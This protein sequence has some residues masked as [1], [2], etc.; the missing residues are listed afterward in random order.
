MTKKDCVFV[1]GAGGFIGTAI[2]EKISGAVPLVG[3]DSFVRDVHPAGV[4][5]FRSASY[6]ALFAG[7][8][9]DSKLLAAIFQ[10]WNPSVVIHLAAETGTGVSSTQQ[11]RHVVNNS[12]AT[13][14][15]LESLERNRCR[16]DQFIVSSSRAVYGEGSW[17]GA[18]GVAHLAAPRTKKDLESG[19][20]LPR[21]LSGSFL[22]SPVSNTPMVAPNPSNVYALT[23]LSQEKLVTYWGDRVGVPTTVF[24]FQNVY[25]PGQAP[26]NPYT[27]IVNL[28]AKLARSGEVIPVYEDGQI[29]RDFV[30]IDDVVD[31]VAAFATKGVSK[32]GLYD[33]GSGVA[34][35]VLRLAETI[36]TLVRGPSPKITDQFRF[37][38]VRSAFSS[39]SSWPPGWK[40]R[41][42][43][44][45]GLHLTLEWLQSRN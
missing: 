36:S 40:P 12:L 37:G 2:A 27:G 45:Q 7:N 15:L 25:G 23:K 31:S 16:V 17:E 33:V 32:P 29:L 21:S 41:T 3:L 19:N 43:L 5:D 20:W 10:E 42:A 18:G 35:S 34:T 22:K 28:F 39:P 13:S 8:L 1:T 11:S 26:N 6:Q 30:F 4:L 14:V 44:D 24:R 38:D 9:T